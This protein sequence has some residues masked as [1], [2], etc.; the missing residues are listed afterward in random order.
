MYATKHSSDTSSLETVQLLLE[1][2]ADI[3]V[4]D[5]DG[6]TALMYATKNNAFEVIR[7]LLEYG[8]GVNIKNTHRYA[9]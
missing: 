5:N 4:K 3:N 6:R 9:I 1:T 8:A 7:L 2:G